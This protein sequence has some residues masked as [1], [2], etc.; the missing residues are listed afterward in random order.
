MVPSG[1]PIVRIQ[2]IKIAV[3]LI[4]IDI[5]SVR[6]PTEEKGSRQVTD[7]R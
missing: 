3:S 6:T 4:A 2:L 5:G 1:S 7:G